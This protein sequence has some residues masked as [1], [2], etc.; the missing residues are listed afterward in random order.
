MM[1]KILV[2]GT[3]EKAKRIAKNLSNVIKSSVD[4]ALNGNIGLLKIQSS[5]YAMIFISQDLRMMTGN[6]IKNYIE[7]NRKSKNQNTP[8]RLVK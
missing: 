8:S 2:V 3:S 1:R 6:T 7:S 4:V 5:E